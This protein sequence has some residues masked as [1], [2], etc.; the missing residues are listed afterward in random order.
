[1]LSTLIRNDIHDIDAIVNVPTLKSKG[2]GKQK[3]GEEGDDQLA[4]DARVWLYEGLRRICQDLSSPWITSLQTVCTR[5][6]CGEMKGVHLQLC[7][8]RQADLVLGGEWLYL[9]A[10]HAS[11]TE[12]RTRRTL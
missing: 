12:V 4:V 9:C 1:M 5:Q 10:A 11:A 6:T 7:V 3:E 8:K 2:K